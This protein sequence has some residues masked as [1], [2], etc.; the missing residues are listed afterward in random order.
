MCRV[1]PMLCITED[2]HRVAAEAGLAVVEAR[3]ICRSYYNRQVGEGAPRVWVHAV[4]QKPI[5]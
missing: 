4:F 1:Y 2:L 3:Y 5:S